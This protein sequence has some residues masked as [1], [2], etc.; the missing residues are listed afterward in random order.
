MKDMFIVPWAAADCGTVD[1]ADP[2]SQLLILITLVINY[3]YVIANFIDKLLICI[4]L[5]IITIRSIE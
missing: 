2:S 1:A 4:R 3:C 5:S